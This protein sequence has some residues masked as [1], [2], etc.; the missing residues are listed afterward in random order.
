MNYCVGDELF[1]SDKE[2]SIILRVVPHIAGRTNADR[3]R[4]MSDEE[5]EELI[6]AADWCEMCDQVRQDGTCHA[7]ELGGP[8]NKYCVAGALNWLQQPAPEVSDETDT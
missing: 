5:L 8:L 1:L 6:C 7:M 2:S 4:A 3:I